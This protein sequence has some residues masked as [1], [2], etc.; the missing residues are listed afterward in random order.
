MIFETD[1]TSDPLVDNTPEGLGPGQSP[2]QPK[3]SPDDFAEGFADA[4]AK[5][6]QRNALI[7]LCIG[8][9]ALAAVFFLG[10]RHRPQGDSAEKQALDT[11]LDLA[12]AKVLI[13]QSPQAADATSAT[14]MLIQAFY[15]YPTNRQVAL[16][17]LQ[18]DPFR[19]TASLIP[20]VATLEALMPRDQ[21]LNLAQRVQQLHLQSILISQQDARCM[22]NGEVF[23]E[24]QH[25]DDHLQ[26][27]SIR[28]DN[29]LLVA[30]HSE[31]QLQL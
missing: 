27:K 4:Q 19:P 5:T 21:A 26:I 28:S 29:V 7:L 8:C 23:Q 24:G 17:E 9:T 1:N 6:T 10:L 25:I 31:F 12:L 11:Q 16:T 30:E 15:E 14:D 2:L 3:P 18:R 22:I 20:P 13:T